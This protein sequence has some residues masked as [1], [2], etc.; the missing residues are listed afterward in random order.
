MKLSSTVLALVFTAATATVLAL[1]VDDRYKIR[2]PESI[3]QLLALRS[4][5]STAGYMLLGGVIAASASISGA[6]ACRSSP[7]SSP[8][9]PRSS[10]FCRQRSCSTMASRPARSRPPKL[11]DV[12][13]LLRAALYMPLV[14]GLVVFAS[15]VALDLYDRERG[16]S[17]PT[18]P[19][20][21]T[22]SPRR[23]WCIRCSS[24]R[25]DRTWCSAASSRRQ[26]ND[27]MLTL[28]ILGFVY[29]ALAIDR[30]SLWCR[31]SPISARLASTIS[32]TRRPTRPAFRLSPSSPRRRRPRD[33]VRRGLAKD[34]PLDRGVDTPTS[35]LD[36][37]PPFKVQVPPK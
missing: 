13:E 23:C 30:R 12:P 1:W 14:C 3:W 24:W 9:P 19:S 18:A 28:L 15:G 31:R 29:V 25:R 21:C 7:E 10:P 16:R 2:M 4:Q 32:S 5:V 35:V 33:P 36:K 6:S 27:V 34:P 20:G 26:R 8:S 37:L 17:G 11:E 22:S